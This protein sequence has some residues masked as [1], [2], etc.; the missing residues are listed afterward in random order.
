[1]ADFE[2]I[3]DNTWTHLNSKK[4][5][6]K[7]LLRRIESEMSYTVEE[8]SRF[9]STTV[10]FDI[11]LFE[12]EQLRYPT[13]LYSTLDRILSECGYSFEV[14]DNRLKPQQNTSLQFYSKKLRDYQEQAVEDALRSERGVIKIATGGGKTV[15][16]AAIVARLNLKTLFVVYSI[17][18]LEQTADE[19]ENMFKIQVGK[20][21]GGYCDIKQINV[22]TIQTL[23]SAFDLKYV[24][25]QESLIKEKIGRE[26]IERKD[27]IR[28]A[29][30]ESEVVVCDECFHA[31]TRVHID[32]DKR[33]YIK[34]ICENL[35]I[36]H[37]LS[38]N[39]KEKRF[40]KKK[41]LKRYITE[42]KEPWLVVVVQINGKEKWIQCTASHKFW[43]LNR[44]YVKAEDLKADDILK[45]NETKSKTYFY[46]KECNCLHD[47]IKHKKKRTY[48]EE[49]KLK[50]HKTHSEKMKRM[51][52]DLI[53]REK[54]RIGWI[55]N[56]ESKSEDEKNKIRERFINLPK[57]A[58]DKIF[59]PS[60]LERAILNLNLP[61][62]AYTGNGKFWM[63]IGKK[64]NGRNWNK[65]PDFKVRGRRKVIE[66]DNIKYWHT[67]E[68]IDLVKKGFESVGFECLYLTDVDILQNWEKTKQK[69]YTFV[70]NH[71]IPVVK[72]VF[73]RR[74]FR[75]SAKK[76]NIEVE[77]NHNYFAEDLLVSNCH[78]ATAPVY[79]QMAQI[80]NKAYFRFNLS[81]TPYR[82]SSI[83]KVLDAYSGKL[84]CNINASYL[85]ERGYLVRPKIYML[86][87]NDFDKY[88]FIRK[89]F[90]NIYEEWIVNNKQRNTMIVDS[91]L[92]LL[93]IG[94]SVLVTVTRIPHGEV[95]CEMLDKAGVKSIA[96]MRGEVDKV[97]RK[98]L[99]NQIRKKEL[100]VLVGTSLHYNEC[101][102]LMDK[103]GYIYLT[104]IG[105]FVEKRLADNDNE[106]WTLS[107][108]NNEICW[109]K[110]THV[111]KHE[112]RTAIVRTKLGTGR[113]VD[114]TSNHSL[115]TL[116]NG[117]IK[118]VLPRKGKKV[119]T[120]TSLPIR[121]KQIKVFD[122]VKEFQNLYPEKIEIVLNKEQQYFGVKLSQVQIRLM[123]TE[124][125]V[126][127][128][129]YDKK[130]WK[131]VWNRLLEKTSKNL[132][133][134]QFIIWFNENVKYKKGRYRVNFKDTLL[135]E[136]YLKLNARIF[137]KR[138]RKAFS[139]PLI[140]ENS[141]E[142]AEVCGMFIG[143][144]AVNSNW[145]LFLS[146][147]PNK[148]FVY[149][150][151]KSRK[152]DT[153]DLFCKNLK[154]IFPE[155]KVVIDPKKGCCIGGEL[156]CL[157]FRELLDIKGKAGT[158][159]VPRFIFNSSCDI[160]MGFLYG[161]FLTDGS[162]DG[163]KIYTFGSISK[164]LIDGIL[165]L[166][167]MNGF[168]K[169]KYSIK[170]PDLVPRCIRPN[171]KPSC[172]CNSSY[173]IVV[174]G[175]LFNLGR[176]T[177]LGS[178]SYLRDEQNDQYYILPII[179]TKNISKEIDKFVYDISVEDS[180]NFFS[181]HGILCHNT[182]ADEGVD[183]P[184]LGSAIMAGGG[185][186]LIKSLQR[187]G[188]TLR[189]YPS[190]END[191]KK[192][193]IIVDFYDR[194]RYLTGHSKKRMKIYESEPM[195][196]V[197]RHF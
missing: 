190:A 16:A 3:I 180:E 24:I 123:K 152:E 195:F 6:D 73:K 37:V 21:G 106:W 5:I 44:G 69:I 177:K 114:V 91:V 34:D 19:F 60:S 188:R 40:E 170:E 162:F 174:V 172:T 130:I 79:I 83:D 20:I 76:Y 118:K 90:H 185:K 176:E 194:L 98:N 171:S 64:P 65:N 81:A 50:N 9:R 32:I 71:D 124:Y 157:L 182:V 142:L 97:T 161:Y 155:L 179:D 160:Q 146:A 85:I 72:R 113:S 86:D 115:L 15:V 108:Y 138:S 140:I 184:A 186:S 139:L 10:E 145:R 119:L 95:V 94:K 112:R 181:A 175:N 58:C 189:P 75:G 150:N 141:K 52:K 101:I 125:K 47:S 147:K 134:Q 67:Q 31:N 63:V 92:R 136:E 133:Y 22:C 148:H 197:F 144:G 39:F 117:S 87:A 26:L 55:K 56:F 100:Q 82:D 135:L 77:G 96:F 169:I 165:G 13:G 129:I 126:I 35:E 183:I 49:T 68:E 61:E 66:V 57:W 84:I 80:W 102:W 143:D 159:K 78:R 38:Y 29:V 132:S 109:K 25:E 17:D 110:V 196:Q 163:D 122:L 166:M 74:H 2:I 167:L 30:L 51:N 70:Y 7:N 43:T 99:L 168:K 89:S 53:I 151:A 23:H 192:E 173:R 120:V 14:V 45:V 107:F 191:E 158:K 12:R 137:W 105:E 28:K 116:E 156:I 127:K 121:G 41:I 93:E 18:L 48:S 59:K 62:L 187:V 27:E 46:C 111:V 42:I 8:Y 178:R 154:K 11:S 128:G 193:A 54:M 153:V 88:K 149:K 33:M 164:E 4:S 104:K 1:M 103:S 36:T 131:K